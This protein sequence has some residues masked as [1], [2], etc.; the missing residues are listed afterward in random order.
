MSIG[1]ESKTC[2]YDLTGGVTHPFLFSSTIEEHEQGTLFTK[3]PFSLSPFLPF[4]IFICLMRLP[5]WG[6]ESLPHNGLFFGFFLIVT[7]R[8]FEP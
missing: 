2:P 6:T 1:K 4:Y 3:L 8:L 5:V 7:L